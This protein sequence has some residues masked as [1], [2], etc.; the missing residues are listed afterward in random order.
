MK[1]SIPQNNIRYD[2]SNRLIHFFREVNAGYDDQKQSA[3]HLPDD[4]GRDT[5]SE[6]DTYPPLFMLRSSIRNGRLWATW[7][8]RNGIR[9]IYG[10]RPAICFTEMPTA[11]FLET[12]IARQKAGQHISNFALTF[13]KVQLFNLNARPVI[14]GLSSSNFNLPH[15]RKR[16]SRTINPKILPK[17]EQ[18]R[19][20]SYN[21][22]NPGFVDWTHEREWRWPY[23]N[24][25]DIRSFNNM[26]REEGIASTVKDIPGLDLY[27][28]NLKHIGVIV[29]SENDAASVLHDILVLVDR[30]TIEA[31]T[32]DHI[33]ITSKITNPN[34]VRDPSD[35]Q[36]LIES[37][38][39]NLSKF[40]TPNKSRDEKLINFVKDQMHDIER[41]AGPSTYGEPGG[42]WLWLVDNTHEL[43]RALINNDELIVNEGGKYLFFPYGFSDDRSLRQRENMTQE[44]AN[45]ISRQFS[46]EAG[47]FSVL[48]S[49]NPDG[50]P[51]YCSD[52][53][54]NRHH[55]NMA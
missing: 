3:P 48:L 34:L 13:E 52:H 21:P 23:P 50:V 30:D 36:K 51:S 41:T 17:A 24:L 20:V 37:A 53:L 33:I 43:T 25:H 10:P 55:Y 9:T 4:W 11:A 12:S 49:D 27:D 45:R 18:Y 15:A 22:N 44:L 7:S 6:N 46:I 35:E 29:N 8:L 28:A 31:D 54:D 26:I 16:R 42:C 38:S 47:R 40:V 14:Y 2:L 32:F 39:I 19:Y 1:K 5:I